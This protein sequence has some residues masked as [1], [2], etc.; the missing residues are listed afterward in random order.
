M[1]SSISLPSFLSFPSS[2]HRMHGGCF[3]PLFSHLA[4]P[5]ANGIPKGDSRIRR[6]R[7]HANLLSSPLQTVQTEQKEGEGMEREAGESRVT[8]QK[9]PPSSSSSFFCAVEKGKEE[10][11]EAYTHAHADTHSHGRIEALLP[12]FSF[13]R[14]ILRLLRREA[15][16][17][18][19]TFAQYFAIFTLTSSRLAYLTGA[20]PTRD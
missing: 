13:P 17:I 9:V 4:A 3:P 1:L 18:I 2:L 10:R 14:V 20:V 6:E 8:L 12:S 11:R 19:R 5:L 16:K 15:E 7:R